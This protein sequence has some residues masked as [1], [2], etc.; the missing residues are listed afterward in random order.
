MVAARTAAEA[1]ELFQTLLEE[2]TA[3]LAIRAK[4]SRAPAPE[5]RSS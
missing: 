2:R 4:V 5:V 3:R 1:G